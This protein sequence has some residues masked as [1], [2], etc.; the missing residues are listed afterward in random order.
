MYGYMKQKDNI[1]ADKINQ[2]TIY[3]G[4]F[5]HISNKWLS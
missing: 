4:W 5:D 1:H 3:A 2:D